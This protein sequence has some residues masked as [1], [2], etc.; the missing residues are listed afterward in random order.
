MLVPPLT[1]LL[2]AFGICFGIQNK[3]ADLIGYLSFG[4][5]SS[6]LDCAYCVGFHCGWL[7]WLL[8]SALL[9]LPI[10]ASWG[11]AIELVGWSFSSAGACFLLSMLMTYLDTN[12]PR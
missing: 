3:A 8:H 11:T 9:Q 5:L 7:V 6:L 2:L 10:T 12:S 1:Y 4:K